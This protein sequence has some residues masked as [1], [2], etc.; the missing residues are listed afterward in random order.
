ML[1]GLPWLDMT[2]PQALL[3]DSIVNPKV[4]TMEGEKV[5]VHSLAYSTSW[6]RGMLELRD[7]D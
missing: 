5:G 2:H 6:Y 3:M 4:K 1:L 7:G